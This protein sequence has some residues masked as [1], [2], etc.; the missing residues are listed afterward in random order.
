LDLGIV[1]TPQEDEE[2]QPDSDDV[3]NKNE[4]NIT[5]KM[6]TTARRATMWMF[7]MKE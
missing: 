2:Y 1:N 7:A 3:D 6:K 4:H 5:M